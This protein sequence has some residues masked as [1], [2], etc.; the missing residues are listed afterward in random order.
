M[1]DGS[2][3][4]SNAILPRRIDGL[5]GRQRQRTSAFSDFP[6]YCDF[7]HGRAHRTALDTRARCDQYLGQLSAARTI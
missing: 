3:R 1:V 2:L 6:Y 5:I 7:D 4:L